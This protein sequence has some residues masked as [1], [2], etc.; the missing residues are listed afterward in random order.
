MSA[1]YVGNLKITITV[2]IQYFSSFIK[3]NR[4][5]H[6]PAKIS[7]FDINNKTWLFLGRWVR[8]RHW[9][10]PSHQNFAVLQISWLP[11]PKI[12]FQHFVKKLWQIPKIWWATSDSK[13]NLAHL[14]KEIENRISCSR[15]IGILYRG[16]V[17]KTTFFDKIF[18][19][20]FF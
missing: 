20:L 1:H 12:S 19:L 8:I 10:F 15:D 5:I 4:E 13:L 2:L 3:K 17:E 14:K 6:K 9:F 7:I 16:N 18:S 11:G